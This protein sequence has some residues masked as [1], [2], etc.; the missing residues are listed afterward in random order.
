MSGIHSIA[1]PQNPV[2]GASTGMVA[3]GQKAMVPHRGATEPLV[4]GQ[5]GEGEF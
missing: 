4:S 2:A 5:S 1:G 3:Q